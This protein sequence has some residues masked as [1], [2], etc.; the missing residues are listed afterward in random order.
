MSLY[1]FLFKVKHLKL[2]KDYSEKAIKPSKESELNKEKLTDQNE[3]VENSR[4]A[5]KRKERRQK[6]KEKRALLIEQN[7]IHEGKGQGKA[8]R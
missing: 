5:E 4:K 1:R 2:E 3:N 6:K 7:H 8:I